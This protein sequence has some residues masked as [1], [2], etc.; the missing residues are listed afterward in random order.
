[1]AEPEVVLILL[2][3]VFLQCRHRSHPCWGVVLEGGVKAAVVF[4]EVELWVVT[5]KLETEVAVKVAMVMAQAP[6]S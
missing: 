5:V 2:V 1:V 3:V 4:P 6:A